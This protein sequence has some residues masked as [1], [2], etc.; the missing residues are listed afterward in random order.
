MQISIVIPVF[1]VKDYLPRCIDGILANDTT[2]TE[3]IL[4]DDGSSDGS[5]ALCDSYALAHP[6]LIRV[7]HQKNS[8]P[9]SARNSGMAISSGEWFLFVDS[10]DRLAPNAL[11][12]LRE[13]I[14]TTDAEVISFQFYK[15]TLDGKLTAWNSG[16][17]PTDVCFKLS[18]RPGF[19]LTQPS[20]WLRLWKRFLFEKNGISF[21]D[22]VWY[23]DIRTVSKLMAKAN[24]ILNLPDRLYYY[25]DRPGSIMNST[26]LPRNR[27]II[28]A[29]TDILDWYRENGLFA[30]YQ[31]ELCALTV[32]H[33]LLAA[34]VRVCRI[35]PSSEIL[36]LFRD[37]IKQTFPDWKKNPYRKRLTKLKRLALFLVEHRKYRMVKKLF[38]LKG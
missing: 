12:K 18:E 35:D 6:N 36:G 32:E 7:I 38:D 15:E 11:T 24:R 29:F 3:V 33:V 26:Q 9:G 25:L 4:V 22:V 10:D 37:F 17:F 1:N 8:G 19:L 16:D 20:C 5:D 2:D 21:P 30:Q 13:T 31:N 28:P 23:E 14:Q 34:S 27:D